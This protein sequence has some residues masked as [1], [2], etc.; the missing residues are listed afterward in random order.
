MSQSSFDRTPQF[1]EAVNVV[2][3]KS[4]LPEV[5]VCRLACLALSHHNTFLLFSHP[6]KVFSAPERKYV[7][8]QD[9]LR[10][11]K[12]AQILRSLAQKTDFS[13]AAVELV[14]YPSICGV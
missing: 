14:R 13:L 7:L 11:L 3:H 12:S 2:A 6:S 10:K 4:G 9:K 5:G 8:P 1:W